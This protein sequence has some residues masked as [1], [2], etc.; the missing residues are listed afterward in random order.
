MSQVCL[1]PLVSSYPLDEP[2]I[3]DSEVTVSSL[4]KD[5][6]KLEV[7]LNIVKEACS[8]GHR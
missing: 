6:N 7:T 3:L 4:L 8:A 1:H 5:C 2:W